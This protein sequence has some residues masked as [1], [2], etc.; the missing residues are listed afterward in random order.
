MIEEEEIQQLFRQH[1]AGRFEIRKILGIGGMGIVVQAF[2]RKLKVLR[3]IKI[4]NPELLSNDS[5]VRRFENEAIIMAG[6]EH[7]NIVKVYDIGEIQSHHF[8]VLEWIDGG[9]LG[10][11]LENMGPMHPRVALLMIYYV[12]DALSVA[13]KR[14]II[15]R[16]IKP[17]NILITKDGMPKVADFGIA[18]MDGDDK[19]PLTGVG[20]GL[21]TPRIGAPEQFANAASVD[22]RADVYATAVTFWMLMTAM[23]P[24]GLLFLH[25]MEQDPG[26]LKDIPSCLHDILKKAV[27]YHPQGRYATM[28]E[29]TQALRDVEDQFP[30]MGSDVVASSD[31]DYQAS[32]WDLTQIGA[33]RIGSKPA[34]SEVPE[35]TALSKRPSVSE[36]DLLEKPADEAVVE[37]TTFSKKTPVTERDGNTLAYRPSGEVASADLPVIE[38][39]PVSVA[40]VGEGRDPPLRTETERVTE[41]KRQKLVLI[42]AL[43]L[44][45]V[46]SIA[47][48]WAY[49]ER[50]VT[51]PTNSSIASEQVL[52]ATPSPDVISAPSVPTKELDA[53]ESSP[54]TSVSTSVTAVDAEVKLEPDVLAVVVQIPVEQPVEKPQKKKDRKEEKLPRSIDVKAGETLV[55]KPQ[56]SKQ[57][58]PHLPPLQGGREQPKPE[59][60]KVQ[61]GLKIPSEDTVRVWLVGPG[62]RHKLP[63]SVAPGTYKV[64]AIFKDQDTETVALSKLEVTEGASLRLSCDSAREVCQKL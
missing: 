16:D 40:N 42:I 50:S 39:D 28:E 62:G 15:H 31:K 35:P 43:V 30:P 11:M 34:M 3:A 12:C 21:A 57:T 54:D 18:H 49:L 45:A 33:T 38:I 59:T 56:V 25:D 29:F 63:G 14:G 19:N 60:V 13:H 51:I 41:P 37:P 32:V 23:R 55:L 52:I 7:P 6:I 61:V 22:A 4:F 26:L 17:D 5:L 36:S 47:L 9:S 2:D 44:F 48:V 1:Q 10:S 20:E 27:A 58:S 8:I 64:V 46:G 24:P 53:G